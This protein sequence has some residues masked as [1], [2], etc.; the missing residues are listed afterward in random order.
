[1][2]SQLAKIVRGGVDYILE[3][4]GRPEI[5]AMAV[6]CV[7]HMG[8][9]G[10][11]GGASAGPKAPIDMLSLALGRHLRGIVQ[12]DAIPQLF[13]P[14]LIEL[15]RSGKFPFELLV[16]FYELENI[17]QAFADSRSGEVIKPILRIDKE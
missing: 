10:L 4:T 7:A 5:L 15:H 2:A 13:I 16:R 11:I 9:V 1:V 14:Q 8:T 3:I 17:D 6:D 12:G